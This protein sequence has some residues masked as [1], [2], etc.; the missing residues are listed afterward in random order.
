M[1][2]LV[3]AWRMNQDANL[4]LL[5]GLQPAWLGDA[6]GTRTRDVRA[7]W[8]H[9]HDVRLRW[10]EHAAPQLVEDVPRL[11]EDAEPTKAQLK[12]ALTG[13]S[14]VV[15][16]FLHLCLDKGKVPSWKGPPESF[17]GYLIAH[18]AHHRGLVMV[19]LRTCGRKVP[20]EL[21]YGQWD[22]GKRSSRR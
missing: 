10:T 20:K 11:G 16:R 21:V 1:S 19:A 2:G 22:W 5:A 17:L 9:V 8:K 7:Q 12:Q 4:F 13:S 14:K 15:E 18:E 6:Y 3:D